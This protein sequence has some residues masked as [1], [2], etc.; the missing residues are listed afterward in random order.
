MAK[1]TIVDRLAPISDIAGVI[2][3][4]WKRT[5]AGPKDGLSQRSNRRPERS[6]RLR[7]DFPRATKIVS[8]ARNDARNV[9]SRA[10]RGPSCCQQV[11]R[12]SIT[13]SSNPYFQSYV[14]KLLTAADVH[15]SAGIRSFF[16]PGLDGEHHKPA[17]DLWP[18]GP[19]LKCAFENIFERADDLRRVLG[20]DNRVP[21]HVEAQQFDDNPIEVVRDRAGGIPRRMFKGMR[22]HRA[23]NPDEVRS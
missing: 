16:A 1:Q 5:F 2:A 19:S 12:N 11:W 9:S 14:S 21:A 4:L 8:T 18:T 6:V 3:P 17:D 20:S 22:D 15:R 23:P 10:M 13:F 7:H